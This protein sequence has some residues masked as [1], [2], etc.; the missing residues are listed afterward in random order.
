M[1][2]KGK[3]KGGFFGRSS[4]SGVKLLQFDAMIYGALRAPISNWTSSL[5][6]GTPLAALGNLGDEV[7]MGF[8]DY[9]AAKNSSGMV[10]DA[11]LKGLTVENARVGEALAQ[12]QLM[13]GSTA[14]GNNGYPV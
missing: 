5:T 11:A 9:M 4:N 13:P 8:I 3:K 12:G 2:K 6:A 7:T 10:R 14:S 1:A